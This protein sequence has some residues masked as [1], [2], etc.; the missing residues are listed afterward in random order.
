MY[1]NLYLH[2]VGRHMMSTYVPSHKAVWDMNGVYNLYLFDVGKRITKFPTAGASNF[3][4]PP[5]ACAKHKF[6]PFVY[7]YAS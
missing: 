1:L 5:R 7:I 4:A 3:I 6:V 2:L